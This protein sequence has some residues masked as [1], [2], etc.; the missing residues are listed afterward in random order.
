MFTF[1]FVGT[2]A[3][4]SELSFVKKL[5][6]IKPGLLRFFKILRA[7]TSLLVLFETSK[8]TFKTKH[9]L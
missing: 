6:K 3:Q 7:K 9:N 8:T 2:L 5:L 1:D 4:F